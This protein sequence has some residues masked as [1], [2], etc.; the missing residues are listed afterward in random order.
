MEK[1]IV[2]QT[3][4][5]KPTHWPMYPPGTEY[6]MSYMESRGGRFPTTTQFGLQW[7]LKENLVGQ[8]VTGEKV[9]AAYAFFARHYLNAKLFNLEGWMHIVKDHGGKLP[10]VIRAVPE[11]IDRKSVV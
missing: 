7:L 10:V 11:G 2:L 1:N 4:S 5:Y 3:D 9:L 8:V 6:V